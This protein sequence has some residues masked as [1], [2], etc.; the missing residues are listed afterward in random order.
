MTALPPYL[1]AAC[2]A[3]VAVGTV[4]VSLATD[5][6][7]AARKPAV[8]QPHEDAPGFSCLTHG[9]ARCGDPYHTCV[10]AANRP[11]GFAPDIC[12]PLAEDA[13]YVPTGPITFKVDGGWVTLP[14]L[15]VSVA[16]TCPDAADMEDCVSA[17]IRE[18]QEAVR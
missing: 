5:E 14:S 1:V 9:N 10:A 8:T 2:F 4:A 6:P 3:V 13:A 7:E 12:D 17:L 18:R 16:D 15:A 11:D